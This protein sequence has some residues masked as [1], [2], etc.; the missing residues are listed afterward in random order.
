MPVVEKRQKANL[1]KIKDFDDAR[2]PGDSQKSHVFQALSS[3]PRGALHC[4]GHDDPLHR[5]TSDKVEEGASSHVPVGGFM[6]QGPGSRVQGPG[7]RVQ[8]PGSRV[9]GSG[10]RVQGLRKTRAQAP[11]ED[12]VRL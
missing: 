5:E 3:P 6:V 12:P 9:Q 2:N 8:G 11:E 10:F 4:D 7:S 1:V